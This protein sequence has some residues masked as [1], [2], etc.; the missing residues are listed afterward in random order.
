P[1]LKLAAEPVPAGK[2][3]TLF[4]EFEIQQA[5]LA[6]NLVLGSYELSNPKIDNVAADG[7]VGYSLHDESCHGYLLF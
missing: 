2:G 1:R 4:N 5:P 3:R 7:L 6:G